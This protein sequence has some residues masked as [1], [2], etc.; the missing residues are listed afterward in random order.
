MKNASPLSRTGRRNLIWAAVLLALIS[1]PVLELC[2]FK[3]DEGLMLIPCFWMF[4]GGLITD[5]CGFEFGDTWLGLAIGWLGYFALVKG[6]LSANNRFIYRGLYALLLC[7][8]VLNVIGCHKD[9][10]EFSHS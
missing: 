3:L 2:Y 7:L 8:L 10:V 6:A 1:M 4:P 5:L 9:V